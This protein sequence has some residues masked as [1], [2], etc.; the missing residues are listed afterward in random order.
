VFAG[1]LD[2]FQS[3][4]LLLSVLAMP[5]RT[6]GGLVPVSSHWATEAVEEGD[7]FRGE[8]SVVCAD[9]I[10]RRDAFKISDVVIARIAVKMMDMM[11]GRDWP[12]VGFPDN[13]VEIL[14]LPLE[15][16]AV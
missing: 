5:L 13:A 2:R 6:L 14:P 7:A 15:V 3:S 10:A 11:R 9:V 4:V 8:V 12:V 1:T 16:E